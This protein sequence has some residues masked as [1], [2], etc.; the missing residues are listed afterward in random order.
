ML[1][2]MAHLPA[3]PDPARD[4]YSPGP[5]RRSTDREYAVVAA[6]VE[7]HPSYAKLSHIELVTL[8]ATYL[9]AAGCAERAALED[10]G[11]SPGWHR[12]T[13]DNREEQ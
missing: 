2:F 12:S 1:D 4:P 9:D 8:A 5:V 6:F 7:R 13:E 3:L 10:A 11:V